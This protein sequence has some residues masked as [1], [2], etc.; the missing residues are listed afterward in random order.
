[1]IDETVS[2]LRC[3]L[4]VETARMR[5]RSCERVFQAAGLVTANERATEAG[6]GQQRAE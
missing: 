1:M 2:V 3:R 5:H 4:K 6:K